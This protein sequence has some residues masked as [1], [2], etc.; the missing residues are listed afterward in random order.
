MAEKVNVL[1]E[2]DRGVLIASVKWPSISEYEADM[3]L[4]DVRA[5][6][7][8]ASWRIALDF[9]NVEFLSSSGIGMIVR[10]YRMCAEEKGGIA[11]FALRDEISDVLKM[12]KMNKL[13]PIVNDRDKA[14]AKL[15]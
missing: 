7:P 9:S 15:T 11:V 8:G 3:I 4:E 5:E 2:I 6:A 14:I 10:L 12:T 1:T 13:F